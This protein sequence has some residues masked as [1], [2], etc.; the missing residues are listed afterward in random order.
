MTV[1]VRRKSVGVLAAAV[2]GVA[3]LGAADA[4]AG[5][6]LPVKGQIARIGQADLL[7]TRQLR[8]SVKSAARLRVRVS[9]R[10]VG[11][12]L[13]V[14]LGRAREVRQQPGKWR[15][16]KLPL[17]SV[18]RRQ[19]ATCPPAHIVL[20]VL[21]LRSRRERSFKRRLRLDPPDCS[22]FFKPRAFWNMPLPA[23]AALDPDSRA[24]TDRLLR[25]VD[26]AQRSD[27][28]PSINTTHYSPPVYT[29]GP[30]QRRV[31]VDLRAEAPDLAAAF[32]D[33]P[34]P[35]SAV[36]AAGADS[37]LVLW[38]PSSDT[39]WEF[40][41][42]H[43]HSD[44]W[45][46]DWGGRMARVSSGPGHFTA[47]HPGWGTAATSLALAGGLI[48]P[49]EFRLGRIDHALAIA[50]PA[51]RKGEYALPAQRTD[52]NSSEAHAV[53]EGARFRLDP[54]LDIDALGLPGPIAAMARA[55][56]R[57]GIVVR[58]RSDT[59]TFFAQNPFSL[60]TDPYPAI[61]SGR[62]P[63]ELLRGFPWSHLELTRMELRQM[64][65]G[66]GG[67]PLQCLLF[68]CP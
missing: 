64:P 67:G 32:A 29:V 62:T 19:L 8:V 9:A 63:S 22:R 17:T 1:I 14:P 33:V 16:S 61:F 35:P 36:P 28:P 53:P 30:T 44:G 10:L 31:R 24:V 68:G 65:D 3:L 5:S 66:G 59:V 23:G 11:G 42:L 13:N 43:R 20:R 26:A 47:P 18:G 12:P 49:R 37:E 34:L 15:S 58:D 6:Q 50:I 54:A 21:D 60:A 56:Q 41:H 48:T 55:A 38:Q 25:S 27:A 52:G 57:Y 7:A 39:L 2:A 45:Q 40:W 51:T 4:P 46:A